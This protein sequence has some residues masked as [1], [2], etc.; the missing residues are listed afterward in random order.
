MSSKILTIIVPSYN[1]EKYLPKCLGSLIISPDLMEQLEVLVVND[2]SKDR[3]SEIAH[4]FED[5]YPGVFKV[6]D[7]KNGNYGSC[8]N[9]GLSLTLGTFVRILDADDTYDT[10]NLE[11]F[12]RRIQEFEASTV[13]LILSGCEL[14]DE[15]G[16]SFRKCNAPQ[17]SEIN[18]LGDVVES[19]A[20][21]TM[22]LRTYRTCRLREIH[23]HQLE[24]V[25][26]T[27]SEFAFLPQLNVRDVASVDCTVYK[28]LLGRNGQTMDSQRLARDFWMQAEV[29]LDMMVKF[30]KYSLIA[31]KDL[32]DKL[33]MRLSSRAEWV[34]RTAVFGVSGH[35]AQIEL[36]KF[37]ERLKLVNNV[38]YDE[39]GDSIYSRRVP[40]RFV[41][42]WRMR[43]RCSSVAI[44]ICKFYTWLS[45]H[46]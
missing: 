35:K 32:K 11:V 38:V 27:D 12:V 29:V 14:V 16:T 43:G 33:R 31:D 44:S 24:G 7:K 36:S 40:Y 21:L 20:D 23:F 2:G 3:T 1:M 30:E 28:Y 17:L 46:R 5:N 10:K 22:H 39:V 19:V 26:Y 42:D 6:V 4:Q 45:S 9:I 15:A 8:I 37:D 34:Y 18:P 13:D 25:S 41:K